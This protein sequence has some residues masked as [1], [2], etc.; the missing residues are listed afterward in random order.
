MTNYF[1]LQNLIKDDINIINNEFFI[2]DVKLGGPFIDIFFGKNSGLNNDHKKTILSYFLT[3]KDLIS[4]IYDKKTDE[5]KVFFKKKLLKPVTVLHDPEKDEFFTVSYDFR[6]LLNLQAHAF[7][8]CIADHWTNQGS[9]VPAFIEEDE[10]FFNKFWEKFR[11]IGCNF[12]LNIKLTDIDTR[13]KSIRVF[14]TL[15]NKS[16]NRSI[17]KIKKEK[18]LK[19]KSF[20]ELKRITDEFDTH[21]WCMDCINEHNGQ[22]T[23]LNVS[24]TK[25]P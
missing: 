3:S 8:H 23:F 18:T 22:D 6:S 15:R 16:I 9:A 21:N 7:K 10:P 20:E 13:E 4:V 14:D 12:F 19:F 2:K 17:E 5:Y 1:K 25:N 24:A 11:K